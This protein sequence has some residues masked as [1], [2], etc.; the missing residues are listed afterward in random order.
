MGLY[1]EKIG[2]DQNYQRNEIQNAVIQRLSSAP[3]APVDG[4]MYYDTTLNQAGFR[5]NGVWVYVTA[6]SNA[7]VS[8]AANS[9]AAGTLQVSGGTDRTVADYAPSGAGIVKVT[10]AGVA[11]V[12]VAKTDYAPPTTTTS[13]LRGD[14]SG[15]FT[16]ATLNDNGT[17]TA[18]FA[19]G[20]FR[21]TGASDPTAAQDF[22]T[23]NYAD[24]TTST[25]S[26]AD[27]ARSNHTGTQTASTISD[28]D[29]QVR[30]SRLDQLAAPTAAVSFNGQRAT[31]AADPT[32]ASDLVTKQYADNLRAGLSQKD[33]ARAASTANLTLSGAQT[34]DG[35]ALAAGDRVLVKNQTDATQNGV[36]VVASGTWTR[37]TDADG[38][39]EVVDGTS[40]WVQ[41]GAVNGDQRWVQTA[42]GPIVLGT[43]AQTWTMDFAATAT[44]AGAG[45]T[46]SG[47]SLNV[48]QG[49]GVLVTADAV[50]VD[51]AVVVR[52]FVQAIGD[53][54]ATSITV[55][56]GL[57]TRNVTWS[58]MDAS[59]Y[60]M[61]RAQFVATTVNTAT[62]NFN[63]A[64]ATSAFVLTVHG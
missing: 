56:H 61:V 11:S 17:P 40:V 26:T 60:E 51:P 18:N 9:A 31:N 36:Y 7:N 34:V 50:A 22:A 63:T 24:T 32:A 29:T 57:G 1:A 64:P 44:T 19:L 2:V 54:S 30:T 41:S 59:T 14:G 20:G 8:K 3:S 12:A 27:R 49:A 4:Q 58:L 45:L 39:G 13:S 62:V 55:T 15:G 6:A 25:A 43:T 5:Q 53:G 28:F 48:G 37:A 42:A 21:F 16:A 46:A 47:N 52:K 33:P 35:V 38:S 10:A 23:K